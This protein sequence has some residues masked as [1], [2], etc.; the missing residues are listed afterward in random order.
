MK[1]KTLDLA[2][3]SISFPTFDHL[4]FFVCKYLTLPGKG[5]EAILLD[6]NALRKLRDKEVKKKSCNV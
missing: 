3:I 1:T 4:Q 6:G 2:L 5:L